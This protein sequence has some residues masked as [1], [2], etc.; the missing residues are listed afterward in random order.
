MRLRILGCAGSMPGP[1]SPASGYLVESGETTLLLDLG[2]GSF[3]PLQRFALPHALNAVV[4]SHLHPDHCADLSALA[5]W[6]RYGPGI[7]SGRMRVLGPAGTVEAIMR[8]TSM[9]PEEVAQ[10]FDVAVLHDREVA[11]IGELTI[12]AHEVLHP[13][14]A[15]G[16]RVTD[17][18]GAV[19]GYTGDTDACAGAAAVA[20]GA[21]LLL[22]E[23]AFPESEPLRGLHLTGTRA[24][25]L[26]REAG[27]RRLV[28]THIQPWSDSAQTRRAALAQFAG[29][30]ELAAAAGEYLVCRYPSLGTVPA[31]KVTYD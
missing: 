27:A 24:G 15:F 1:D 31:R 13:V 25:E 3:G 6:L 19:L 22:A 18:S 21:D 16:F 5:V 28:L 2:S 20:H 17:P 26:A 4:L 12:E 8:L 29:P 23:A 10:T 30:V 14:P 7:G 11:V 9:T